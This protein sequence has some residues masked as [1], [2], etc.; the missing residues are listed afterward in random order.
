[1]MYIRFPLSLRNV[2]ELLHECGIDI[3]YETI[4]FCWNRFGPVFAGEIEKRRTSY[5]QSYS[6]WRWHLDEVFV[7]LNGET[8]YVLRA[9]D[10]EG[11]A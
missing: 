8:H 11:G 9:V 5:P 4:R 3:C 6:N 7:K 1:M 2:E 10:H